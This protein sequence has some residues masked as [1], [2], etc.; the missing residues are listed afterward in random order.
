MMIGDELISFATACTVA[1]ASGVP[2][3]TKGTPA[4]RAC[5]NCSIVFIG[6][7]SSKVERSAD[8]QVDPILDGRH[9]CDGHHE[10]DQLRQHGRF[11]ST[12]RTLVVDAGVSH[13]C[14]ALFEFLVAL[15]VDDANHVAA[16]GLVFQDAL[17]AQGAVGMLLG[18]SATTLTKRSERNIVGVPWCAIVKIAVGY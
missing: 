6:Q 17:A 8:V 15:V 5:F 4:R 7:C 18:F 9:D 1:A 11:L 16:N 14:L 13:L 3:A 2:I 12:N 10:L